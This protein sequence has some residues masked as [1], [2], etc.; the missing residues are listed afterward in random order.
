MLCYVIANRPRSAQF[1]E[2]FSWIG[3]DRVGYCI[4]VTWCAMKNVNPI[5]STIE[6]SRPNLLS[7]NLSLKEIIEIRSRNPIMQWCKKSSYAWY[8]SHTQITQSDPTEILKFFNPLNYTTMAR[9]WKKNIKQICII[10]VRQYTQYSQWTMTLYKH[11]ITKLP[12]IC[13]FNMTFL[14]VMTSAM[15]TW[16]AYL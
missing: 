5:V 4:L 14:P 10:N 1:S 13:N 16:L 2:Y 6:N 11:L 12:Q 15:F 8:W 7:L 3:S 9:K